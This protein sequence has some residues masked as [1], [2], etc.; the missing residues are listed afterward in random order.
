MDKINRWSQFASAESYKE[1]F[2]TANNNDVRIIRKF[3]ADYT[4]RCETAPD[5]NPHTL[6][7]WTY[8]KAGY[9]LATPE[10]LDT[11]YFSNDNDEIDT[12][13][14][15]SGDP[16]DIVYEYCVSTR[17][18]EDFKVSNI[19]AAIAGADSPVG[20]DWN[21]YRAQ[22][23]RTE[24]PAEDRM[25]EIAEKAQAMLD[26]M[27][28]GQWKVDQCYLEM[29]EYGDAVE[30]VICVTAVPVLNGIA[31]VRQP[32]LWSL[33][34]T[35]AYASNYYLTDV[36]FQFSA[37]GNLV[38]FRMYSPTDIK[39]VINDNVAVMSMEELME[40]AK[41]YLQLSDIYTY[42]MIDEILDY[43]GGNVACAVDVCT[44]EYN[45][46]RVKVPDTD[47][48]YYYVPGLALRGSVQYYDTET[49]EIYDELEDKILV[50]INGVDGSV[51][52]STNW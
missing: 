4:E 36:Q 10:E 12:I 8:K 18:K 21:I 19:N 28:L 47:E 32:Q 2:G 1:L 23:L 43:Y 26:E 48:S 40:K 33:K 24:K 52:N 38:L 14:A 37:N 25:N 6:C 41:T 49:G 31:A 27:D 7:D 16:Y 35:E 34:S 13:V 42:G 5:E 29:T 45:L 9:Y 46:N 17:D 20:I 50:V 30:Y 22:L 11:W 39:D 15:L 3:I 51:I 44:M